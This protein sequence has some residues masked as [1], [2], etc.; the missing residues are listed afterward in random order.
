VKFN[1]SENITSTPIVQALVRI[2]YPLNC[3]RKVHRGP[4]KGVR[5][6]IA[7]AMGFTYAWGLGV[8]QWQFPGLVQAGMCVYD[9][10]ANSGQSTLSLATSVGPSGQVIAFEPVDHLFA[11]LVHNLNLNS[12]LRVTPICAA[13][14]ER[15]GWLEFQ[16]DPALV[17]QGRLAGV[18]PGN[19]LPNPVTISVRAVR[20]DDYESQSWPPP[21]FIKIDV[22]GGAGA[23]LAGAP[24]LI[25]QHRPIIYIE[26]HGPEE[27]R[28]ARDLLIKHDYS[29]M[30]LS[31]DRV[32]DPTAGEFASLVCKPIDR[33][34]D[35]VFLTSAA[36]E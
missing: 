36:V 28:A 26:L 20:L 33:V 14:S 31:G 3:V 32:S 19:A 21:H 13:A 29:A 9:V 15:N 8:E 7:P 2:A 25:A 16:F 11:N 12:S 22:E 24:N 4:L 23:V 34:S 1:P 17:T 27:R 5:F 18:E 6:K 35:A 10:G 30:T